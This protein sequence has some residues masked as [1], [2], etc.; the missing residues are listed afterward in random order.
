MT[1]RRW[2]C[3]FAALLGACCSAPALA[4]GGDL[5]PI[6]NRIDFSILRQDGLYLSLGSPFRCPEQFT[7]VVPFTPSTEVAEELDLVFLEVILTD[8]DFQDGQQ[9]ESDVDIYYLFCAAPFVPGGYPAPEAPPVAEASDCGEFDLSGEP[10][11]FTKA[12]G[13][14]P[15]GVPNQRRLCFAFTVPQ[16][17]GR[18][19]AR[20]RG[21]TDADAGWSMNFS[22]SN[23]QDPE[24][25]G[26]SGRQFVVVAKKD[27]FFLGPNPPA[28]AD[29]GAEQTVV[30]GSTV[31]LDGSRTFDGTNVG[32]DPTNPEIFERDSILFTWEWV[33][34]PT[35]V[36]PTYPDPVNRPHLAEVTL[37]QIG[38]YVY[39][40]LVDDQ[41][42][43]LPTEDTVKIT[44][45]ST[46]RQNRQ[47]VARIVGPAGPVVVGQ[48]V[49][50][51]AG[52]SVDPDGDPL[53]YRWVQTNEIGGALDPSIFIN[54]FQP[55]GGLNSAVSSWQALK[56]GTYFF[57]LI[58]DDGVL[59]HSTTT[60]LVVVN[61]AVAGAAASAGSPRDAAASGGATAAATDGANARA[62]C[63]PA[64][65]G[66]VLTS[67]GLWFGRRRTR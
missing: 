66:L 56:A 53:T 1:T 9:E 60:T 64:G 31:Q 4:Q 67:L 38:D 17:N 36:D 33:S 34:G 35:R 65:L 22:I 48:I 57:R 26:F 23:E 5:P 7:G 51:N 16:L 11:Q 37:T 55:L 18:N 6:I 2:S 39:R 40:L 21:L 52:T 54:V 15:T 63:G 62:G 8:P 25:T 61:S 28:Y 24:S 13:L 14:F 27:P 3:L 59:S 20:L 10:P 12:T 29:A 19:Q 42:N 30:A 43:A 44:V 47:P 58:V 32:F 41:V 50:L 45:V 49:E 46:I